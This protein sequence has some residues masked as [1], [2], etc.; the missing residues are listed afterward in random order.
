ML[1][2]ANPITKLKDLASFSVFGA[3]SFAIGLAVLYVMYDLANFYYWIAVPF[4][5]MVHLAIHYG[6][7]RHFIFTTSERTIEEGFLI[8]VLIGVAEIIF[9]TG[10]VTLVVEYAMGDVYWTRISAGIIA[11]I[12]GFFAN[13]R[14]NFKAL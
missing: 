3:L 2:N 6:L 8:F 11:A 4:S 5:V 13:A 9:I 1:K 10:T 14:W 12:G 7:S